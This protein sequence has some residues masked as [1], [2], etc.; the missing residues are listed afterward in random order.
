YESD[1]GVALRRQPFK[2][3][4]A[5]DGADLDEPNCLLVRATHDIDRAD[6]QPAGL[7]VQYPRL[8]RLRLRERNELWP[9]VV[10]GPDVLPAGDVVPVEVGDVHDVDG[11]ARLL[12]DQE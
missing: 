10:P 6:D 3:C 5:K 9:Q 4:R 8:L 11:E 2:E 1:L 12:R 7:V